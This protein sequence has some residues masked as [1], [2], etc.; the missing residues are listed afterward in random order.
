MAAPLTRS[1]I[2][3]PHNAPQSSSPQSATETHV[4]AGSTATSFRIRLNRPPVAGA[5]TIPNGKPA[6]LSNGEGTSG[7][8]T[9]VPHRSSPP[10]SVDATP[11]LPSTEPHAQ[12]STK[13]LN[14]T[15]STHVTLPSSGAADQPAV[16]SPGD[17]EQLLR[18]RA[19]MKAKGEQR[20]LDF[21]LSG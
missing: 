16:L 6:S 18:V 9:A 2:D 17:I 5:T 19:L 12:A 7:A 4:K 15:G 21:L 3:T 1:P 20:M 10:A 13:A 11:I 8:V 14:G